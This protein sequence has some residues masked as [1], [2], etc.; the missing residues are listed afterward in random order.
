MLRARIFGPSAAFRIEG[1]VLFFAYAS[2]RTLCFRVASRL[3]LSPVLRELPPRSLHVSATRTARLEVLVRSRGHEVA[4][5]RLRY[6][7][8]RESHCIA[9]LRNDFVLLFLLSAD[10]YAE[11]A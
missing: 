5:I 8:G 3:S 4:H 11:V 7:D 1:I 9:S 2:N 10:M 6:P